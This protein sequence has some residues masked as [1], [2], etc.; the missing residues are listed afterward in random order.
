MLF[1]FENVLWVLLIEIIVCA[2][3]LS[4]LPLN[5]FFVFIVFEFCDD[6]SWSVVVVLR[7][8]TVNTVK[9]DDLYSFSW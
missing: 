5:Q 4:A 2:F 7:S 3:K 8:D 9:G 1:T 6:R